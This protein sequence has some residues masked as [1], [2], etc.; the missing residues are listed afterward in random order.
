MLYI[1]IDCHFHPIN[2]YPCIRRKERSV[3]TITDTH[4]GT[5]LSVLQIYT[6]SGMQEL[7]RIDWRQNDTSHRKDSEPYGN[8]LKRSRR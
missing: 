6:G 3:L 4:K 1:R 2:R 8:S 5:N 7:S